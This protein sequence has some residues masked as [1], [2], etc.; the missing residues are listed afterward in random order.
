[1]EKIYN[2]RYRKKAER[3]A[4]ILKSRPT[5]SKDMVIK[6]AE[7]AAKFGKL[8][9]LDSYGRHLNVF[10]YY[11]IDVMAL[12]VTIIIVILIILKLV[13]KLIKKFCCSRKE[14]KE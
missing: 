14:K 1:M 11:L 2:L 12:F 8:P 3:L 13:F 4:E 7:F 10:Q 5:S 9:E 6:H